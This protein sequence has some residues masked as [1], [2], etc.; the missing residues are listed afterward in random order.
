MNCFTKSLLSPKTLKFWKIQIFKKIQHGVFILAQI[1]DKCAV[2]HYAAEVLEVADTFLKIQYL[3]K[4]TNSQRFTREDK[5][6]YELD[7]LDV[8]FKLPHP[9]ITGGLA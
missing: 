3:K 4:D 2:K 9:S 1:Q 7:K 5:T 6:S 8:V